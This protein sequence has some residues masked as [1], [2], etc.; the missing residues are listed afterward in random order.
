M[1][2]ICIDEDLGFNGNFLFV[3]V[4]GNIGSK[5]RMDDNRIFVNGDLDYES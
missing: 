1:L 2:F 3:I 4:S 5:F